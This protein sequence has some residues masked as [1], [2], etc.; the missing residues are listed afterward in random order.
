MNDGCPLVLLNISVFY[1]D[2]KPMEYHRGK[3][4]KVGRYQRQAGTL[5]AGAASG[6]S[7]GVGMW[8]GT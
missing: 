8:V 3:P 6:S 4:Q 1:T 5:I 7:V 2:E